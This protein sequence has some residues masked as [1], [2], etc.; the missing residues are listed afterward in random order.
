MRQTATRAADILPKDLVLQ[1]QEHLP[2]GGKLSIPKRGCSQRYLLTE[3]E[4]LA[5]DL[6]ITTRSL[7]LETTRQL[8]K[9]YE[10]SLTGI[11]KIVNRTLG[12][13]RQTVGA[14]PPAF[15]PTKTLDKN[16]SDQQEG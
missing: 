5:Q 12:A 2:A 7:R 16:K 6:E 11:R 8:A 1:I 4:R 14:P 9:D 10:V 3:G 13:L 15:E